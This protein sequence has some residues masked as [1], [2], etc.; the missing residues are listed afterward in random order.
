MLRAAL[1]G[2][3]QTG[4]TTLFQPM[5]S[6]GEAAR[7]PHGKAETTIGI[8]KVPDVRLNRLTPVRAGGAAALVN[9]RHAT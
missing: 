4:R 2:F 3:G 7:A 5:T 6:A 1:I 9:F 8:S